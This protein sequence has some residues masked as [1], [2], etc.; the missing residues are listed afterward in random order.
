MTG[1]AAR[2][3]RSAT[4]YVM[5]VNVEVT[6]RDDRGAP[7]AFLVT[8]EP[9]PIHHARVVR[10]G[11]EAMWKVTFPS[12]IMGRS[13]Q[14][15]TEAD[16]LKCAGDLVGRKAGA[17]FDRFTGIQRYAMGQQKC[18]YLMS[19]RTCDQSPEPGSVWCHWHPKGRIKK[20]E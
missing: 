6:A 3:V 10:H 20:D 4:V 8:S 13:Y 11:R 5:R 19:G 18:P 2:P 12:V 14:F 15:A 1:Y 17:D 7:N 16:A 9:I